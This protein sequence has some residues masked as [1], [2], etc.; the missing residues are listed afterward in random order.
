MVSKI[1][2]M[3][4]GE[5]G[6]VDCFIEEKATLRVLILV[7]DQETQAI[8]WGGPFL[9]FSRR[10]VVDLPLDISEVRQRTKYN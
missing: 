9:G 2:T 1:L 10:E 7:H 6:F 5:A 4:T 8:K 3:V